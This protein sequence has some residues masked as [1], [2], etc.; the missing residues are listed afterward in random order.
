[1]A[2]LRENQADAPA[3]L[4]DNYG[5]QLIAFC[6]QLLRNEDAT[7]IAV[8]DTM[9]VAQAHAGRLRDP[10]LIGPWLLAGARGECE[11]RAR[12]TASHAAKAP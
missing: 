11:R 7:L 9:I 10:G 3:E 1:V 6:W 5:G 12:A 8:R 2:A 4:F